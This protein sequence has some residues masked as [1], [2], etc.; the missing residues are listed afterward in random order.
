MNSIGARRTMLLT[1]TIL[2]GLSVLAVTG[3]V[4]ITR[5]TNL[6]AL[7]TVHLEAVAVLER[8][9]RDLRANGATLDTT[10]LRDSIEHIRR[11]PVACLDSMQVLERVELALL[12]DPAVLDLCRQ[13]IALADEA[14][15]VLTR[16]QVGAIDQAE[17]LTALEHA[18]A[19]FSAHSRA[20]LD[21]VSSF[22]DRLRAAVLYGMVIVT[23]L[24]A[25]IILY[26]QRMMARALHQ[27]EKSHRSLLESE[28]R[29]RQLA[30]YDSLTGLP[31]RNLFMDRLGQ[32]IAAATRGERIMALLYVDLDNFKQI[33][34][35]LGH[36]AGDELLKVMAQRLLG[37]LRG[38]DTVSRL[39]GDEFAIILNQIAHKDD[40]VLVARRVLEAA[41]KPINTQGVEHVAGASIGITWCPHDGTDGSQLL[42]NAD[43]A[44]YEA[45]SAG[46]ND[47]RF[48]SQ[49]ADEHARLRMRN[50]ALLRSA[51][52]SGQLRLHF[53]PIVDLQ[54]GR[55]VGAEAL[56]RWQHP[57]D[58]LVYPDSFIGIAEESGS[59]IDIGDWVLDAALAQCRRW[60]TATPDFS[61]AV[62]VSVRQLRNASFVDRLAAQLELHGLAASAL[63]L[64]ITESLFLTG[65]DLALSSLHMLGELG[66]VLN[67]DDFGTGYS[68]FGY[69]RQLPFQVLKIDRSFIRG[70][71]DNRDASAVASAIL[72]MAQ[73]LGLKVVAEGVESERHLGFLLEL[74]CPY[75]QGYLFAKPMPAEQFDPSSIYPLNAAA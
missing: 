50:E 73:S 34:D 37:L 23:L 1:L 29:N 72:G 47:Y 74:G 60:Q 14:L 48:Y 66:V 55:T 33:N 63:H 61:I 35:T 75:G 52:E 22:T 19:G 9:L 12:G 27:L 18:A 40:A 67:I 10:R 15:S 17:T 21:P 65:D 28:E 32:A 70:V 53:Q 68:S 46:R 16:Y 26:A 45:K 39:G 38:T 69:L 5:I 57:D 41:A 31:N 36:D 20:F 25:A 13:D 30:L 4:Q 54:S 62:N 6:H 58:G 42:K 43:M 44:M 49:A 56:L 64:E 59:I 3:M 2:A 51:P 71:P 24:G 7:N 11:Q 8:Q